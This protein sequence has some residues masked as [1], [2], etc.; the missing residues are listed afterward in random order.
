M[1]TAKCCIIELQAIVS[2]EDGMDSIAHRFLSAAVKVC[3]VTIFKF[4]LENM[5]FSRLCLQ[6]VPVA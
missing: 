3:F 4:W 2:E 5:V 1:K 6:C